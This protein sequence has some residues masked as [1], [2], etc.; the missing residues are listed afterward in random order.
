MRGGGTRKSKTRRKIMT[1]RTLARE[2]MT[3]RRRW[4]DKAEEDEQEEEHK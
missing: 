1:M 2:M 3:M 4:K